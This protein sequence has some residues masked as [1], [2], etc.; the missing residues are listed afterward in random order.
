[1]SDGCSTPVA[2]GDEALSTSP[3]LRSKE[4]DCPRSEDDTERSTAPSNA[5]GAPSAAVA[6]PTRHPLQHT[7]GLWALLRPKATKDSPKANPAESWQN[8]QVNVHEVD[9]IE[10]FWRLWN[11]VE[12]PSR[13]GVSDFSVFKKGIAPA[14]E[15]EACRNGGRWV[16]KISHPAKLDEMWLLVV[17]SMIGESFGDADG[18]TIC[19]AVVSVRPKS[20]K[21]ALWLSA[22]DEAKVVPIGLHLQKLLQ[23]RALT[24]DITFEDFGSTA[25]DQY[26]KGP[27]YTL[28]SK[29][30]SDGA[31]MGEV[32]TP[33]RG[34]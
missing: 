2:S 12:R 4:E 17:L 19:G 16:A 11:N 21:I 22:H 13:L 9:T 20:S 23:N 8:S 30:A 32:P 7:W 26:I 15:D 18:R 29:G 24:T 14:W 5:D 28:P 34:A 27:L 3:S 1:M 33:L 6:I 10:D 25:K 31:V